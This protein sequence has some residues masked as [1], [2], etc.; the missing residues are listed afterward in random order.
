MKAL[1]GLE[2]CDCGHTIGRLQEEVDSLRTALNQ[3]GHVLEFRKSGWAIEHPVE[4]RSGSL[5]DCRFNFLC[6]EMGGPPEEGLGRYKAAI[7]ADGTLI[8]A[9]IKEA[10]P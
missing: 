7:G 8:L 4:C 5:L 2:D 9:A 3:D 10:K 6:E 1:C